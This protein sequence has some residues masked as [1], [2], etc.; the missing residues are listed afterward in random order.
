MITLPANEEVSTLIMKDFNKKA[1]DYDWTFFVGDLTKDVT[2]SEIFELFS[3]YG[4][5][6]D[7]SLKRPPS[8]N[9]MK[10]SQPKI[11]GR[12]F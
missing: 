11:S 4:T 3:P 10:V 5:V 8:N 1:F 6:E 9:A 7:V 12:S 2:R